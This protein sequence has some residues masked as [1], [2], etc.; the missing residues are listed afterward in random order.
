MRELTLS[1]NRANATIFTIDPRGLAG[2]VDAGQYLD[3]SEWRTYLQKT[4]SSL[5]YIAEETGGF[6][7]VNDND[8]VTRVQADRCGDQRLLHPR[9]LLEQ[10]RPGQARAADRSQS[11]SSGRHGR[12]PARV[13]AE[14]AGT[15]ADTAE[16]EVSPTR[17]AGL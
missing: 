11:R 10:S 9:L 3:Q 2:I 1:A 8:F 7:V 12:V 15:P 5:R 14:A 6:A 17:R 4:Q 13:F 16:E